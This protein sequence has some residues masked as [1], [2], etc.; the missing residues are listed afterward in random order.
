M[1]DWTPGGG[2][3][4]TDNSERWRARQEVELA[5]VEELKRELRERAQ[6]VA[7][8]E[9]ELIELARRFEQGTVGA[10][11]G[12]N[13]EFRERERRLAEQEQRLADALAAAE[14]RERAAEAE[15]ALAQAER[16]RLEERERIV[17]EVEREL[18][19]QRIKL[20]EERASLAAATDESEPEPDEAPPPPPTPLPTPVPEPELEP[21]A[22]AVAD[23]PDE[24]TL[25][26]A[27]PARRA[28]RRRR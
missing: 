26:A 13:G 3:P 20:Q 5:A 15:H 4:R 16:E 17:H 2:N 14:R 11:A 25:E 6:I 28:T 1:S 12:D 22:V 24:D 27:K 10:P 19:Q 18:A 9:R 8:R 7:A 23:P 21:A